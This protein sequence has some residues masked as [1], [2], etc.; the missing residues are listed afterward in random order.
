M[1][2]Y[3]YIATGFIDDAKKLY[4]D[5]AKCPNNDFKT[6]CNVWKKY[7]FRCIFMGC[8]DQ[9][10]LR[11]FTNEIYQLTLNYMGSSS[12]DSQIAAIYLLYALYRN[13]DEISPVRI[14]VSK[15]QYRN[16]QQ[17]HEY[18]VNKKA[19][20]LHYII[21]YL[22]ANCLEL[23][24]NSTLY[25][26]CCSLNKD[27]LIKSSANQLVILTDLQQSMSNFHDNDVITNL[28]K[29]RDQY[30]ELKHTIMSAPTYVRDNDS[31][32]INDYE[33][34][35]RKLNEILG[36]NVNYS[37]SSCYAGKNNKSSL[38]PVIE[39]S[40]IGRRRLEI[41]NAASEMKVMI[42]KTKYHEELIEECVNNEVTDS[43]IISLKRKRFYN[44]RLPVNKRRIGRPKKHT[45]KISSC[46]SD[47][48]DFKY[49]F[50]ILPNPV[51]KTKRGPTGRRKVSYLR[52]YE[53]PVI[54]SSKEEPINDCNKTS[55]ESFEDQF[56]EF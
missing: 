42:P 28:K 53:G 7:K 22:K 44:K 20:E 14:R 16:I 31:S 33:E 50:Q 52:N 2:T 18:A 23:V 54:I 11:E 32:L 47:D 55:D 30:S 45:E 37:D 26:P 40:D 48:S 39:K 34:K 13:Q 56:I 29:M 35:N 43:E 12:F 3:K 19:H 49:S 17:I 1:S 5:F 51:T 10:E 24:A 4:D 27:N 21:D 6:F 38:G 25:G 9:K 8:T 15:L 36:K 46:E 41:K